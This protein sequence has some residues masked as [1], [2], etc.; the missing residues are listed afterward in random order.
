MKG[1]FK[2]RDW[3]E[4]WRE[5]ILLQV[6][7]IDKNNRI[8]ILEVILYDME[9]DEPFWHAIKIQRIYWN[10]GKKR[11]IYRSSINIPFEAFSEFYEMINETKN[12]VD[13]IKARQID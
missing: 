5:E 1:A 4:Q 12:K 8:R 10:E 9:T 6:K 7:E 2:Y 11:W 13:N 3:D